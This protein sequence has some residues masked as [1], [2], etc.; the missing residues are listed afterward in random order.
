MTKHCPTA[1][2]IYWSVV[3]ESK[4]HRCSKSQKKGTI[5]Y[6]Q[7]NNKKEEQNTNPKN[8][9]LTFFSVENVLQQEN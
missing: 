8:L 9:T 1:S 3:T 7:N 4:Y 2:V 6:Q 5:K